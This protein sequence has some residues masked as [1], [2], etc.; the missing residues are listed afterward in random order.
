MLKKWKKWLSL[1]ALVALLSVVVGVA[2]VYGFHSG[3]GD[4]DPTFGSPGPTEGTVKTTVGGIGEVLVKGADVAVQ[5]DQQLLL[6]GT[7]SLGTSLI[8]YNPDGTLDASFGTGGVFTPGPVG[9]EGH[10]IA[11][12]PDGKIV[13]AG[14]HRIVNIANFMV[15]RFNTDGSLDT[16]FDTD[17]IAQNNFSAFD[18]GEDVLIQPDGKILVAGRRC[19]P[20]AFDF[21]VSRFNADGSAD[22]A[23]GTA[24]NGSV[25]SSGP[26]HQDNGE[27]K[28]RESAAGVSR[29]PSSDGKACGSSS[30]H[31][32]G[33]TAWNT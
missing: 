5:P 13:V 10:G 7:S 28:I 11:L 19:C 16:T 2:S 32:C 15:W 26:Y 29:K 18:L 17:G 20:G 30:K 33:L 9:S 12:Q 1:G 4:L 24:G 31:L 3:L 23:F 22:T 25:V 21:L 27:A 8:R 14:Y 6:T